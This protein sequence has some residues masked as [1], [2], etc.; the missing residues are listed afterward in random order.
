MS[1]TSQGTQLWFVDPATNDLVEVTCPTA[2]TLSAAAREQL[3]VTCLGD[4]TRKYKRGLG[5][6]TTVTFSVFFDT[7]DVSHVLLEDM[8][9]SNSTNEEDENV[10]FVV[11]MSDGT[12]APT[13][14][15]SG[16]LTFPTTRSYYTFEGYVSDGPLD[17]QIAAENTVEFSIQMSGNRV[18]YRKTT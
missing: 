4:S 15:T 13:A 1:Q 9:L 11:G 17:I 5:N 12:A 10:T 6:P 16:D 3:D 18:P 7:S 14:D 8:L 2:I